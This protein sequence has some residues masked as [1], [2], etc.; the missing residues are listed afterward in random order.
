[1]LRRA[2]SRNVSNGACAEG[3]ILA[4]FQAIP[5]CEGDVALYE[6]RSI[7]LPGETIDGNGQVWL[8]Y[9]TTLLTKII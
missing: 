9:Q 2:S 7:A 5:R 6:L 8:Q 1:M 3:Y 4:T